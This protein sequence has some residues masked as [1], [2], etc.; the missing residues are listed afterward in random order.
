MKKSSFGTLIKHGKKPMS[1][2]VWPTTRCGPRPDGRGPHSWM[3]V[4]CIDGNSS[5]PVWNFDIP[6]FSHKAKN[7]IAEN[8]LGNEQTS[9]TNRTKCFTSW[10]S[11]Q[12]TFGVL[13]VHMRKWLGHGW[14]ACW[15]IRKALFRETDSTSK[16]QSL[17]WDASS[18]VR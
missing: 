5:V 17:P 6:N 2:W 3:P 13:S 8:H 16:D 18:S 7:N 1:S 9:E 15:V 12:E 4:L 10:N 14:L 11:V